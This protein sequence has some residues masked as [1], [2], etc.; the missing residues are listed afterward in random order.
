MDGLWKKKVFHENVS[1]GEKKTSKRKEDQN[2]FLSRSYLRFPRY[3][4]AHTYMNK[5]QQK[6]MNKVSIQRL[7]KK[8]DL[9]YFHPMLAAD[10]INILIFWETRETVSNIMTKLFFCLKLTLILKFAKLYAVI[11][12]LIEIM[13]WQFK[14]F[15]HLYEI[16]NK[17]SVLFN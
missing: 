13:L 8:Q 14:S 17:S 1:C 6:I 3:N 12:K 9:L 5:R 11:E 10:N 4:Q 7:S 16:W 2:F 15:D